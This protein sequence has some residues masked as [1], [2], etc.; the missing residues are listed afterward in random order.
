MSTRRDIEKFL[1]SNGIMS[2]AVSEKNRPWICTLYYGIDKD[3]KMYIVTDPNSVHGKTLEKNNI[4]AFNIFDSHQKISKPKKGVQG[5]GVCSR[6]KGI[7][8]I[9]KGLYLWHRANPG[10]EEKI[11]VSDILKKLSDT[12]IYKITP[13]NL[14]YFNKELYGSEEYGVLQFD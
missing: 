12:K 6:V 8:E 2:L 4:V 3:L 10:I 11:T 14:K 9:T 1:F 7:A 13:T 5:V